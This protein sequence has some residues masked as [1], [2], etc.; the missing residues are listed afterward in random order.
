MANADTEK[1]DFFE[2]VGYVFSLWGESW[3]AFKLNIWT[4][5]GLYLIPLLLFVMLVTFYLL[6][7]LANANEKPLL[8]TGSA[9]A[10]IAVTLLALF[11]FILIVP[12]VVITQ[13]ESAKGTTI[14]INDA[15]SKGMRYI[16]QYIIA[17]IL[18]SL[19]SAGPLLIALLLVVILIG[20]LLL[21][22]AFAWAFVA[23]FFLFLVPLLIVDKNLSAIAAIKAS[24]HTTR[25]KW[26]WVLALMVVSAVIS[27]VSSIPLFGYVLGPILSI[28]YLCLP[29]L[30]YVRHI[31]NDPIITAQP[32]TIVTPAAPAAKPKATKKKPAKKSTAKKK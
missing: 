31:A 2:K 4:F 16:V 24:Y 28:I 29:A 17:G 25:Q 18:A 12:A 23:A 1:M 3:R 19:I 11:V 6:P 13:L 10:A 7:V 26:Q 30:V 32:A 5:V 22:F 9:V 15:L 27:V 8:T 14:T 20:L 21:P